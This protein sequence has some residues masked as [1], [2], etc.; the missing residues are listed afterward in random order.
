MSCALLVVGAHPDDEVLLAGGLLARAA[1]DGHQ[2]AVLSMTRG[3]LGPVSDP[4]LLAERSLA[5]T[6][7]DELHAA[8]AEL[9]V[10]HV[11]CWRRGDGMLQW[12][13]AAALAR[14]LARLIDELEP[15]TVIS[16]GEDGLY[17][18]PDHIAV[19]RVARQAVIQSRARPALFEAV[20]P[21]TVTAAVDRTLAQ[22]GLPGSWWGLE[23]E[24][25]GVGREALGGAVSHDVADFAVRKLRA[26]RAH[27]TQLDPGHA[28]SLLPESLAPR[29]L[30]RE[31]LRPCV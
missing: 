1:A 27:R 11:R 22:L 23:P 2:T 6:R 20:W 15:D 8:G 9:G 16:F 24:A 18:H 29:L 14:Q 19:G 28:L 26:L 30:G 5:D 10:T 4:A 31:W 21:M 13:P 12:T 7:V 25:I 17:G 3:E